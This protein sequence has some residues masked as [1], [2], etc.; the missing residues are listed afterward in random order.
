M[1]CFPFALRRDIYIES[2]NMTAIRSFTAETIQGIRFCTALLKN[3]VL[4]INSLINQ[5]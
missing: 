4:H 5:S 3:V 1:F 2:F